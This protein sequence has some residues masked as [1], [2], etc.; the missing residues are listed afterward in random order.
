MRRLLQYLLRLGLLTIGTALTTMG[1]LTWQAQ[2]FGLSALWPVGGTLQPH[3]V[4][5]LVLGIALLPPCLWDIFQLE[6]QRRAPGED[7]GRA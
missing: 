2:G 3:P 5:L 4:H 7:H 1:L 6:L